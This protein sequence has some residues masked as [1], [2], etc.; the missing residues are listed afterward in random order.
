LF[1]LPFAAYFLEAG[2]QWLFGL[3]PTYWAP[4]LF[5]MM[6]ENV[7]GIWLMAFGGIVNQLIWIFV[8]GRRFNRLLHQ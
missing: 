7:S 8:L 6:S 1:L 3:F 5:W 2:W 4:K